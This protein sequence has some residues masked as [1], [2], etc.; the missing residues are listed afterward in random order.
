MAP[1]DRSELSALAHG[2]GEMA[3]QSAVLGERL[4]GDGAA[5]AATALYEAERSLQMAERALERARR[6]LGP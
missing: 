5:E 2:V 3:R 1:I 6:S 4:D